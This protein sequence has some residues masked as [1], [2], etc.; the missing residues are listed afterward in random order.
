[1]ARRDSL[2]YLTKATYPV[3]LLLLLSFSLGLALGGSRSLLGG[4]FYL[5]RSCGSNLGRLRCGR[6]DAL[7]LERE[8]EG[9]I[10]SNVATST[11]ST[12][13]QILRM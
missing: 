9:G 8:D 1:M 13:G 10:R 4:L 7:E 11:A 3:L 12:I 6:H 5:S 2:S